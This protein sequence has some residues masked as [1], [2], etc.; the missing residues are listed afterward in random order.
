[1]QETW[2]M[3]V[4]S[5]GREGPLEKGVA[6]HS[7]V[8]AWRIPWM[9]EPARPQ[10]IG[11]QGAGCDWS[12]LARCCFHCDHHL[13]MI[14]CHLTYGIQSY[15]TLHS[16]PHFHFQGLIWFS[17]PR[18][19]PHAFSTCSSFSCVVKSFSQNGDVTIASLAVF[20]MHSLAFKSAL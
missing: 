17:G 6:A 19:Q 2:E 12:N 11:R 5:L 10:S 16:M 7:S 18:E 9:E 4:W 15:A 14:Y 1:M 8:L 20:S 3:L 13:L